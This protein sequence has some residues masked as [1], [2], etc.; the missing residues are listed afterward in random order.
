MSTSFA[1]CRFSGVLKALGYAF[2]ASVAASLS[3]LVVGACVFAFQLAQ[4]AEWEG[5]LVG[6][7]GTI[8]GIAGPVI[9]LRITL[10]TERTA[11]NK[12]VRDHAA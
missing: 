10:R 12:R 3:V 1:A 7:V 6:A 11:S 2:G 5:G 8:A 9:G 4:W